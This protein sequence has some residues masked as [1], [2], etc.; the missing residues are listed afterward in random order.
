MHGNLEYYKF[1]GRIINGRGKL[2]MAG[3]GFGTIFRITTWG[4][5]MERL[6]ALSLTDARQ[7][8]LLKKRISINIWNGAGRIQGKMSTKRKEPDEA[9]ILSG[10]WDGRTTGT[11]ISIIIRN[12]DA[13]SSDYSGLWDVYRPGHADFGFDAKYGF[14]DARGGGRSSGRETSA[15]VA[16]RRRGFKAS[17]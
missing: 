16:A 6:W 7:G 10:V 9:E 3:S 12:E 4:E 14:R 15:R 17:F 5:S 2:E 13:H 1:S 8:W 11:P